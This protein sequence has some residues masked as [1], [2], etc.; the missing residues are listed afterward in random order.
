MPSWE[1]MYI[2]PYR[3][4]ISMFHV[5]PR[6]LQVAFMGVD[7]QAFH[8]GG[9]PQVSLQAIFQAQVGTWVEPPTF[10]KLAG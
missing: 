9:R 8:G 5:L 10:R 4:M 3:L 1:Q 2:I 6:L 7:I